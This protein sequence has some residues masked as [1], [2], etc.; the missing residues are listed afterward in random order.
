MISEAFNEKTEKQ[1]RET[2]LADL[3]LLL[4]GGRSNAA[5]SI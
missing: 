5:G 3:N 1:V 2:R 4:S